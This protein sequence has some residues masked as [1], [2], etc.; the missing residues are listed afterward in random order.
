MGRVLRHVAL[1]SEGEY[2]EFLFLGSHV[3]DS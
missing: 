1:I 2:F 3:K